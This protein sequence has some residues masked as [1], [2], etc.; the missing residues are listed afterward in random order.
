MAEAS[1]LAVDLGAESGRVM[2]ISLDRAGIQIAQAHRFP[3]VQVRIGSTHHWD[4]L[5]LFADIQEGL[6][7]GGQSGPVS[8]IGLDTWGID[9][10][11]LDAQDALLGNPVTYRDPRTEGMQE[12]VF[13]R[14][15]RETVFERTGVQFMQINTLFQLMSLAITRAPQLEAARAFLMIPDLLNF[16][17]S[18]RK[19]NEYT[20]AST[21]QCLDARTRDWARGMLGALGIPAGMFG[22]VIQPGTVLGPLREHLA[23]STGLGSIPV[24]AP[25]THDTGSAVVATPM[26]SRDAIYLS[27]GTWSLLGIETDA[28]VIDERTRAFNFTNEGGVDGT[29]RLLKNSAG[30]WLLQACR[31]WWVGQ[32]RNYDYALLEQMAASAA[33]FAV[34][35]PSDPRFVAP[36]DMPGRI[37]AYCIETG[38]PPPDSDDAIAR[39]V[40]VSLALEYR[41]VCEKLDAL[42]GRR[43]PVIHIIGGGSQNQTLNQLTADATQRL[44]LAGPVEATALGNAMMQFKALG[45][46]SSVAEARALIRMA[47]PPRAV[48]P[49]PAPWLDDAFA[50]FEDL[51]ARH[52]IPS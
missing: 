44:V 28:P 3:N 37:R 6:R 14:L 32:G 4:V 10:A 2:R 52:T 41:W 43:L 19:A 48:E 38:Q 1:V 24:I 27:S 16:W 12:A 11:L 17:L 49:Q 50:R 30:L 51:R 29:I 18:G 34:I 15:P 22:E 35:N 23:A 46:I 8:G 47:L 39:T 20:D 42:A 31:A 21:T 7:A 40:L 13:A 33:S 9:F 25:A 5:R 45:E 26:D 36:G